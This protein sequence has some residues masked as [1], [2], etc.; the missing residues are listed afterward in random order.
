M[1]R[2]DFARNKRNKRMAE[3]GTAPAE[4][5]STD[6]DHS[7]RPVTVLPSA[8]PIIRRWKIVK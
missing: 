4:A 5:V 8:P 2:L 7:K 3:R 6:P 1:S